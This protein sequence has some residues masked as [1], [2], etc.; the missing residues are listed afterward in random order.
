MCWA[1]SVALSATL[2]TRCDYIVKIPTSFSVNLAMAGAIVMYDRVRSLGQFA[3][4]PLSEGGP[5]EPP[6]AHVY[7]G[8][9]RA[10]HKR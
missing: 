9:P 1:L 6:E 10:G 5:S 2:R 4:R 8:K 3:A 7:G